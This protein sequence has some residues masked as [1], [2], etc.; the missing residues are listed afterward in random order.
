MSMLPANDTTIQGDFNNASLESKGTT[1]A[2]FRDG[3]KFIIRTEGPAGYVEDFEIKYT[4]G[5]TPLQ[6]FLTEIPDGRGRLQALHVAWDTDQNKW[7]DLYPIDTIHSSDWMHWTNGAMTWNT[8]C[9]DCH[10][11]N[12]RKNYNA[13]TDAYFTTWSAIN[14]SCEACNGPGRKNVEKRL[15]AAAA[16]TARGIALDQGG[17]LL[18]SFKGI[19]RRLE[20]AGTLNGATVIDDFAHNPDKIGA[21]LATLHEFPGRLLIMFQPHGFG[22]LRVMKDELIDC[23]E[24]GVDKADILLMPEPVYFG[25]TVERTVTS[26]DIVRGVAARGREACSLG[27]RD[28]SGDK[29]LELARPGAGGGVRVQG[30]K[31]RHLSPANE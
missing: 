23:L 14:V 13:A 22:P 17:A 30:A 2:F 16:A 19:Q 15:G 18:A 21:T 29:L 12:L 24:Q 10:S 7:F 11:T 27:D 31:G 20:I 4:F 26:Q 1:S 8:M 9:A 3:D 6:Q 28:A 25:G 5:W